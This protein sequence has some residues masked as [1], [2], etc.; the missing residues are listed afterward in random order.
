[1]PEPGREPLGASRQFLPAQ[2]H[3]SEV[4]ATA[5]DWLMPSGSPPPNQSPTAA[6]SAVDQRPR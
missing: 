1:M 3:M 2:R 4:A 5:P 6:L